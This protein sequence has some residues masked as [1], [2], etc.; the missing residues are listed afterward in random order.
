MKKAA[1]KKMQK[2]NEGKR[3]GWKNERKPY[4]RKNWGIKRMEEIDEIE[5]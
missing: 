1:K 3:L 4:K 2:R 5:V